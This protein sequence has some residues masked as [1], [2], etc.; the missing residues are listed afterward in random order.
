M[1]LFDFNKDGKTDFAEHFLA[2]GLFQAVMGK[3]EASNSFD[4]DY[5]WRDYC[6]DCTVVK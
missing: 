1:G 4:D 2:Y 5:G 3:G 6:E